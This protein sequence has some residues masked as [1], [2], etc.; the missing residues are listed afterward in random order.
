MQRDFFAR[1]LT[2]DFWPDFETVMGPQGACYGCWCTY[3][4][5]PAPERQKASA[6]EK[7]AFIRA[8]V[9]RESP[10]GIIG[11]IDGEPFGWVQVGPRSDV[12]NWNSPR[13]V[14]RPLEEADAKDPLIWAVSCFMMT[15][16][17][18]GLGLSHALLGAAVDF[19]RKSGARLIEACPMERA[20]QS[21]SVSLFVGPANIFAAAGF[22]EV[23][24]RKAG[25][26]LMRLVLAD[27]DQPAM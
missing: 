17:R 25:R 24:L 22:R 26:P 21:K 7:K 20:K 4:R 16:K 6:A 10:P 18:R 8:R 19:A 15:N 1:P 14:S 5:M 9:G 23:A 13:T 11:Y 27:P 3:F 2:P 12:P